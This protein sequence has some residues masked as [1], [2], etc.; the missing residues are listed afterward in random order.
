MKAHINDLTFKPL[1][2]NR[3]K[4][5]QTG[6]ILT[7]SQILSY[8]LQCFNT[9]VVTRIR[10]SNPNPATKQKE[11]KKHASKYRSKHP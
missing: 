10:P 1:S 3:Y 2:R 5:N 8:I 4:C 6:Q 11:S 9:G 7:K